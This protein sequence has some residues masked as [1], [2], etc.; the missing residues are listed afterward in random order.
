MRVLEELRA[1]DRDRFLCALAAPAAVRADL[2]ALYAFSAE[3]AGIADKVK[4]PMLGAI[5]L[6]WWREALADIGAGKGHRHHLVAAL[7]DLSA[8]RGV[9]I[10]AISA[11]IDAREADAENKQPESLAALEQ[12]AQATAGALAELA[13][14]I[15]VADAPADWR[16]AARKAGTAYALTGIVRATPYLARHG[17]V[18][19]PGIDRDRVLSL[20]GGAEV[21]HVAEHVADLARQNLAA[22]R[23]VTLARKAVPALFPARLATAQLEQLRRHGYDPFAAGSTAPSGLQIWRLLAARWLGRI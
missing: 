2:A 22:A 7:G 16:Q 3:L 8:R 15:C 4:E 11:L 20:K 12:Y 17:R 5:R 14:A 13:L 10:D 6:Q 9:A 19:L 23:Q 1:A 18:L 21:A